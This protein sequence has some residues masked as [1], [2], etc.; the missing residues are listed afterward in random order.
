MLVNVRSG[1]AL[2]LAMLVAASCSSLGALAPTSTVATVASSPM[3]G[4]ANGVAACDLSS[5]QMLRDTGFPS[6]DMQLVASFETTASGVHDWLSAM[7]ARDG[8]RLVRPESTPDVTAVAVCYF[9]GDFGAMRGP[10]ADAQTDYSRIVVVVRDGMINPLAA[11]STKD[12]PVVDPND[13]NA[14]PL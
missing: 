8:A 9:D 10:N 6:T 2:V 3:A 5:D 11:G 7:A 12:M 13:P 1:G 4:Q 14:P